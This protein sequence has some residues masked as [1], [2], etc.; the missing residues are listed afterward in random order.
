[1]PKIG[2][3]GIVL[4]PSTPKP[5]KWVPPVSCKACGG[6]G[7][8]SGNYECVPCAGTGVQ[9]G[10]KEGKLRVQEGVNREPARQAGKPAESSVDLFA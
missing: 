5:V 3:T 2:Q 6:C 10:A 9:G 4:T 8:S 7:R 1:M